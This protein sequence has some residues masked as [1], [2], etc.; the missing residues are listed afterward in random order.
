MLH[1][2]TNGFWLYY[3]RLEKGRFKWPATNSSDEAVS[4][5]RRQLN[6]LLDGLPLN[7]KAAH[8]PMLYQAVA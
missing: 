4:I 8:R 5:T 1:W 6:C 3:R 2:Q 7:Q